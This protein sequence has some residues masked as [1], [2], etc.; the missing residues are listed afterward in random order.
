MPLKLDT[1]GYNANFSAFVDF[2]A[3]RIATDGKAVARLGTDVA[4]LDGGRKIVAANPKADKVGV[5]RRK[6]D[7]RNLNND[8]RALFKEAIIDMFGGES[9]IP[10]SV[11]KAMLLG[12]YNKGKPLTVR[13]IMSVKNA[14]DADGT[15]KARAAREAVIANHKDAPANTNEAKLAKFAGPFTSSE[16]SFAKGVELFDKMIDTFKDMPKEQK[17][18]ISANFGKVGD[19][20][21]NVRDV[22]HR[23]VLEDAEFSGAAGLNHDGG[24]FTPE[25][26]ST[27]RLALLEYTDKGFK[28]V[29][30]LSPAMRSAMAHILD[31]FMEECKGSIRPGDR[32]VVQD[33]FVRRLASNID[34]LAKLDAAGKLNAKTLVKICYPDERN[35]GEFDLGNAIYAD[36]KNL[37]FNRK[38]LSHMML[39]SYYGLDKGDYI[40]GGRSYTDA[41]Y[42]AGV[43]ARAIL[44]E[45]F[46]P[47]HFDLNELF[48]KGVFNNT[49]EEMVQEAIA[50]N[51]KVDV[52]DLGEAALRHIHRNAVEQR[53]GREIEQI[54]IAKGVSG[55]NATSMAVQL[56]KREPSL[57]DTFCDAETPKQAKAALDGMRPRIEAAIERQIE[58]QNLIAPT[59]ES[60]VKLISERLGIAPDEANRM[61]AFKTYL[62]E[63]LTGAVNDIQR[64]LQPGCREPGFDPRPVFASVVDKVIGIYATRHAAI[65]ALEG[66]DDDIKNAWKSD[67]NAEKKPSNFDMALLLRFAARIDGSDLAKTLSNDKATKDEKIAASKRFCD[68]ILKAGLETFDGWG[69]DMGADEHNSIT[70]MALRSVIAK[71]PALKPLLA[72]EFANDGNIFEEA[73]P[74]LGEGGFAVSPLKQIALEQ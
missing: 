70:S 20:G 60:A 13:R 62:T 42:Q 37:E 57:Y 16:E 11:R 28:F 50:Q 31:R 27:I 1:N 54:A 15:A 46:V 51:R 25:N 21:G 7:Q 44:G 4:P 49:V 34:Q 12:D 65:D 29:T 55:F 56:L 47:E 72:K 19:A 5:F 61:G 17:D 32:A 14:I 41:L 8:V 71:T 26:N 66:V 35:P 24:P 2:A 39:H 33:D 22:K 10:E 63:K 64:G 59:V 73:M 67:I 74:Q 38:F 68:D 6:G 30:Q 58:L 43:D 18:R 69:D 36:V 40:V 23:I 53:I 52:D 3:S 9:K 48:R 45:D